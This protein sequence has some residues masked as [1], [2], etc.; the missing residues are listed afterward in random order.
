VQLFFNATGGQN[1]QCLDVYFGAAATTAPPT[2]SHAPTPYPTSGGNV[3]Q[4][5]CLYYVPGAGSRTLCT[6]ATYC[7]YVSGWTSAGIWNVSTC[8]NCF[9]EELPAKGAKSTIR[10]G[11]VS[12]GYVSEK[13]RKKRL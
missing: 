10:R 7:P 12:L 5:C 6:E 13:D 4:H 3:Q 1:Y 8:A 2:T 11:P 9:V